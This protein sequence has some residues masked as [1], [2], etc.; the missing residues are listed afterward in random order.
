MEIAW[1]KDRGDARY[2]AKVEGVGTF[3]IRRSFPGARSWSIDR[4]GS[5]WCGSF[6]KWL[7]AAKHVRKV[8]ERELGTPT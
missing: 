7:H 8:A 4:D 2:S 3:V 1:V 5:V 6:D